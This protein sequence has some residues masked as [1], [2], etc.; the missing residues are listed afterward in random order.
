MDEIA[1]DEQILASGALVRFSD[2]RA[3]T[4]DSPLWIAGQD[5][6]PPCPAPAIGQ[7][8]AEILREAGYC[9]DAIRGLQEARVIG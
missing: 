4:V 6:L 3:L 9:E 5:K 8:S 7:H 1:D 2:G